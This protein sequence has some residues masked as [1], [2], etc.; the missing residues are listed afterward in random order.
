MTLLTNP[1][2]GMILSLEFLEPLGL[3]QN[4]LAQEIG[5]PSNRINA[6]VRGQRGITADT[7]M[8]LA[9]FFGLS[10]GFWLHLQNAYDLMEARRTTAPQIVLQKIKPFEYQESEL[11]YA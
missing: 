3:S 6:I 1:H 10:E 5:V 4:A 11:A 8:R 9:R 7:D 2:P